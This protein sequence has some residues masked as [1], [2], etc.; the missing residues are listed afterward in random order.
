MQI[1]NYY[2]N[3]KENYGSVKMLDLI[4]AQYSVQ[5]YTVCI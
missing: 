4:K 5:T 2:V 1:L 3:L